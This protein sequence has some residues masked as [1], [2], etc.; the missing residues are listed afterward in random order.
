MR[1]TGGAALSAVTDGSGNYTL[2]V[3]PGWTGSIIPS[4]GALYFVPH[5]RDYT[6]V[7]A[8]IGGQNY[9]AL[10]SLAANMNSGLRGGGLFVNWFGISGVTYQ[11]Q[12]SSNLFDWL[13]YGGTLIGT[14]GPAEIVV[15]ID[16]DPQKFFRLR[17]NN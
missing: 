7:S 16:S 2:G 17:A 1:Q 14:N 6:N 11:P 8:S 10:T 15:P 5:E 3:D 13:P 12:Y 9:L 4:L